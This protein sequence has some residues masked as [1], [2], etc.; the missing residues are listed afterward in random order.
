[1]P[2][3]GSSQH[4]GAI[5]RSEGRAATRTLCNCHPGRPLIS[6]APRGLQVGI[7]IWNVKDKCNLQI[8]TLS[9]LDSSVFEK[10]IVFFMTCYHGTHGYK[11]KGD[12]GTQ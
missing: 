4:L 8:I 6:G 12:F 10:L 11:R 3:S 5:G 2:R 9:F 7:L 1:M